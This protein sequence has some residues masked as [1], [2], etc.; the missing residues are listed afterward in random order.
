MSTATTNSELDQEASGVPVALG[1]AR[2]SPDAIREHFKQT[3]AIVIPAYGEAENLVELLPTIPD[4]VCGLPARVLIVDDGSADETTATGLAC[5]AAVATFAENRGGGAALRCGYALM[6][7]AEARCVVTMDAD[8]QH[9]PEDLDRIAGPVLE[10]RVQLTQGS[11]VLGH[12]E[13]GVFARELGIA[14]FNRLVS[15][16]TRT[17]ITDCSNGYR[18]MDPEML[19][20]LDL[21]QRQF[22]TSEFLIE[23]LTRG[24]IVEEVPVTVVHRLHGKTKKPPTLRYGYGFSNAIFQAWRRSVR[25]RAMNR[26]GASSTA[27]NEQTAGMPRG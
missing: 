23:A 13:P 16:L 17:K 7:A 8:G 4:T 22:H 9:L 19:P 2:L 21:R 24:F 18:G 6:I 10:G 15:L 25:R 11:R 26:I 14:L 27:S 3:V 20:H 12:R 1:D 5:G